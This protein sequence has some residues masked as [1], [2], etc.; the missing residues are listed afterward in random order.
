MGRGLAA[1]AVT[2][3]HTSGMY[4]DPRFDLAPPFWNVTHRGDL[5]VDFFFVLSGFI[6]LHAH[7]VD[8]GRPG[9]LP[10]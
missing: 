3:F 9:Q 1:L 6:I 4:A 2:L 8:L 10:G 7:R 5:G